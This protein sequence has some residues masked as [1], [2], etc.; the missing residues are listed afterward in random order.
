MKQI[1]LL[2][3]GCIASVQISAQ[4]RIVLD[5]QCA[6]Q[7]GANGVAA[8]AQ[9]DLIIKEFEGMKKEQNRVRDMLIV[10]EAHLNKVEKVQQDISAFSKEGAAIRLF[11][12]KTK[13]A[14]ESLSDLTRSIMRSPMG[15]AASYKTIYR[16]SK[17]I[18]GICYDM[19]GTVVDGKF[20]LPSLQVKPKQQLNFL[21][22]QE[23]L[24]FYERCCYEMDVIVFK[25]NQMQLDIICTNNVSTALLKISPMAY[26]N[27]EYG[28]Q[29]ARDIMNLWK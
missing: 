25:I 2:L 7:A 10:V 12:L 22:P 21:E 20:T 15:A 29:I 14:S 19:I 17:D 4:S 8:K 24:A 3:V 26:V 27:T 11:V 16:L 23:R 5:A 6:T 13:K 28:K 18:Y 1:L 9:E